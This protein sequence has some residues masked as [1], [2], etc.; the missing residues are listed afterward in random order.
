MDST[1]DLNME[2]VTHKVVRLEERVAV[3]ETNITRLE[4]IAERLVETSQN[5]SHS[6]DQLLRK[7]ET[8]KGI[9]TRID[10]LEKAFD[11][12]QF[13]SKIIYTIVTTPSLIVIGYYTF[14]FL[15]TGSIK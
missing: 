14:N 12:A 7:A 9:E 11:K 3:H 2:D 15:Q 8:D 1:N 4:G 10:I 5:Q 6:V 13:I